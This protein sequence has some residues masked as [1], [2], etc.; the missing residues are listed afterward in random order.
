MENKTFRMELEEITG[1]N[2]KDIS[3]T[4]NEKETQ[5]IEKYI[6]KMD[7]WNLKKD[8]GGLPGLDGS[9]CVFEVNDKNK[10][11]V[12]DRWSPWSRAKENKDYVELI[13]YLLNL[14]DINIAGRKTT[15]D[16]VK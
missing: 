4:L 16:K 11:H 1:E 6:E 12:I 8:E 3:K 2:E 9:T 13:T 7:F 15:R 10:Y 5:E 14:A